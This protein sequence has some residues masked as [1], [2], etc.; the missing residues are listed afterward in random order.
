MQQYLNYT[1]TRRSAN[2]CITST[3]KVSSK[4]VFEEWKRFNQKIFGQAL[5]CF[6]NTKFLQF[7]QENL[8]SGGKRKSVNFF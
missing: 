1:K 5:L 7:L 4:N 2:T 8:N 6:P 3:L